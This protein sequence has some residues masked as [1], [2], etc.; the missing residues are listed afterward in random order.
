MSLLERVEYARGLIRSVAVYYLAPGRMRATRRF[1]SAFVRPG[2]LCFDVGANAGNR[3]WVFAGLGARV[4]MF[5]PQPLF[6]R[7]LRLLFRWRSRVELVEAAVGPS[8]GKVTL[9]VSRKHPTVST[10]STRFRDAVS[11]AESFSMV[12]WP[13]EVEVPAVTLDQ[14]IA[15]YGVPTFTKIDVE[16]FEPDVL[17]GLSQPLPALSFEYLSQTLDAALECVDLV[18]ALGAYEYNV[19]RGESMVMERD[20]EWGSARWVRDWL[21]AVP[22]DSGSGDVYARRVEM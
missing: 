10:V 19:S 9:Q 20:G 12:D 8:E 15:H 17:R 16:G 14:M 7:F 18:E 1:Y 21:A 3:A 5:E 4:V 2:E 11:D 6:A 13:D 22:A